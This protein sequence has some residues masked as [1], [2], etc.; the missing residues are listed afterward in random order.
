MFTCVCL[1]L[2]FHEGS[3]AHQARMSRTF[4]STAAWKITWT[5]WRKHYDSDTWPLRHL[6][7]WVSQTSWCRIRHKTS[8]RHPFKLFTLFSAYFV[9][10]CYP[11]YQKDPFILEE[12]PH[13]YFSGNAPTLES[14]L[15]KGPC[16]M[17]ILT[18]VFFDTLKTQYLHYFGHII[19]FEMFSSL[20]MHQYISSSLPFRSWW[21]GSPFGYYSRVQQHPNGMSGQ[22]TYSWMW[23][24][25][26]LCLLCWWRWGKWDEHQPLRVHIHTHDDNSGTLL[27]HFWTINYHWIKNYSLCSTDAVQYHKGQWIAVNQKSVFT[28]ALKERRQTLCIN[29]PLF[30]K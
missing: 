29:K 25:Q 23:A 22:F 10:G 14:K 19:Q 28:K 27:M 12:C 1:C 6:I 20:L 21:P 16:V 7:L 8:G 4:R 11:F 18:V 13:I 2:C 24:T 15:I 17:C 9:S 3:W 26:L 30:E 5:Y